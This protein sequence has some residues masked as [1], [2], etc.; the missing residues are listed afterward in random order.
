MNFN[1]LAFSSTMIDA[2]SPISFNFGSNSYRDA[3][4]I[5]STFNFNF[6]FLANPSLSYYN[7]GN[8]R[9]LVYEGANA[10]SM[11]L[12]SS[13]QTIT[14]SSFG[15]VILTPKAEIDIPN[16]LLYSMNCYGGGVPD[17][18]S[19]TAMSLSWIDTAITIQ[20]PASISYNSSAYISK[21]AFTVTQSITKRFNTPGMKALY[22]FTVSCSSPLTA[23]S[24]FYFTF[25]MILNSRLD[26]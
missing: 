5:S 6:G 18:N 21:T 8:F 24:R 15:S 2:R 12:S 4:F 7:V 22:S 19:T 23:N 17:G 3:F 10:S 26:N 1:N 13:W 25:P 9:C 20:G 11:S 14:L 16:S